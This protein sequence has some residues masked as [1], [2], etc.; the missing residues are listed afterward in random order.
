RPLRVTGASLITVYFAFEGRDDDH[1]VLCRFHAK[2]LDG[3][4]ASDAVWVHFVLPNRC[5]AQACRGFRGK[6]I[7][8]VAKRRVRAVL[9]ACDASG[10]KKKRCDR[11]ETGYR[12]HSLSCPSAWF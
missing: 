12:G 4:K 5:E 9:T 11:D 10:A 2:R 8:L 7:G 1:A 3:L 6:R